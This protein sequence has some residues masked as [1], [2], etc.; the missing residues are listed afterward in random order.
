M[1]GILIALEGPDGSGKST[2]VKKVSKYLDG[3]GI[4]HLITR[5][6]GGTP[7]GEDIRKI[8]LDDKN[9]DMS[10]TTEAL[11]YAASRAQLVYETIYPNLKQGNVIICERFVLSSLVYQGIARGLGIDEVKSINDFALQGLKPD[12]TLFFDVD[13][14]IGLKR[15]TGKGRGDRLEKEGIEFHKSVYEGYKKIINI[16]PEDIK[17]IDASRSIDE[18]FKQ[19]LIEIEDIMK[20]GGFNG[21][22]N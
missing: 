16:Y 6:P 15:K 5:E 9:K 3:K 7:I 19:V 4:E 14:E 10:Y 2:I 18:I 8:I 20:K 22:I 11:L 21:I 12:L 1:T 17:I 13:P